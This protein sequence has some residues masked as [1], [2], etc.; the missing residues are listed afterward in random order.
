LKTSIDDCDCFI[1]W[2][3]EEY[4]KSEYCAA[5]LLYAKNLGKIILPFGVFSEIKTQLR[6]DGNLK[7]LEG[8]AKSNPNEMSFFEVLRR[9]DET[10]FN[11]EK[12][13][14]PSR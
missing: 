5:E 13:A 1:A 11:F 7:F 12:M 6:E 14:L 9:I 4:F 2:L 3:N 10:L 8:L